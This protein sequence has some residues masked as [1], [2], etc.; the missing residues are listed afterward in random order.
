MNI[1]LDE[2]V[3]EALRR[4]LP[5]HRCETVRRV[6]LAGKK[7]GVLLRLAEER[8]YEVLITVDQSLPYQQRI[9]GRRISVLVLLGRSTKVK[10]LLR[11][12]PECCDALERIQPGEVIRIPS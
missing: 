11:F 9:E 6:G 4:A 7:N 1:L 8:G 3:P 5:E 12:I 10:D 2:C